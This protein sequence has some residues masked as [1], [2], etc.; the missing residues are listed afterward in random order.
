MSNSF[1]FLHT[2]YLNGINNSLNAGTIDAIMEE[3]YHLDTASTLALMLDNSDSQDYRLLTEIPRR[4]H[5]RYGVTQHE[6][7]RPFN[8]T[9]DTQKIDNEVYFGLI[10]FILYGKTK[11]CPAFA[12]ITIG[13]LSRAIFFL[14][15]LSTYSTLTRLNEKPQQPS[16]SVKTLKKL[17]N[18]SPPTA[19]KASTTTPASFFS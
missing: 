6:L 10:D 8:G 14:T 18:C 17:M 16:T 4:I 13:V 7:S 9:L 15:I 1:S 19:L 2:V 12:V 3:G 11:N 5:S